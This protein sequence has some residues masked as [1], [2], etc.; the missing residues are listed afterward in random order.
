MFNVFSTHTIRNWKFEQLQLPCYI[1]F[2]DRNY[3][4]AGGSAKLLG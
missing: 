3:F 2:N 1:L 4:C